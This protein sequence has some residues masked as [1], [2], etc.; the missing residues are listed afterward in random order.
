MYLY[1]G[2]SVLSFILFQWSYS[3]RLFI[4]LPYICNTRC[5]SSHKKK[6]SLSWTVAIAFQTYKITPPL[7]LLTNW[8]SF[9]AQAENETVLCMA[10]EHFGVLLCIVERWLYLQ[11]RGSWVSCFYFCS[12]LSQPSACR[13]AIVPFISQVC[14]ASGRHTTCSQGTSSPHG[15]RVLQPLRLPEATK[16]FLLPESVQPPFQLCTREDAPHQAWDQSALQPSTELCSY[17]GF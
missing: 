4:S 7:T 16:D 12:V 1:L 17:P 8:S 10:N 3:V 11:E 6:T 5:P 9:A 14:L 15:V 13:A 2:N